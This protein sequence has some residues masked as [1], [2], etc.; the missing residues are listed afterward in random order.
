MDEVRIELERYGYLSRAT[1]L[2][3]LIAYD[4]AK[5][6]LAELRAIKDRAREIHDVE[7]RMSPRRDAARYILGEDS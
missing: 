2:S 3:L 5:R 4:R 6:E 7:P 1:A